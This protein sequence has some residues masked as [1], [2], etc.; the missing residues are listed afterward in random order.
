M[1]VAASIN[2]MLADFFNE[3]ED[4]AL[5]TPLRWQL[6]LQQPKIDPLQTESKLEIYKLKCA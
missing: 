5:Q 1:Q 3:D 4:D 6:N 2:K